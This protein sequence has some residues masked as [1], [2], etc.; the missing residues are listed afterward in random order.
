MLFEGGEPATI[1]HLG[2]EVDSTDEVIAATRR[3][4]A[5]GLETRVEQGTT[6]CHALQDKVWT[7]APDGLLWEVY[8]VLDD[9]PAEALAVVGGSADACCATGA[10]DC[11]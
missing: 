8:T 9:E 11:C 5:A 10:E 1:N 3:L 7:E 4:G 2:V 6:C